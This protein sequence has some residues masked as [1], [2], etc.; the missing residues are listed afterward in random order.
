MTLSFVRQKSRFATIILSRVQRTVDAILHVQQLGQ[1][2][3]EG[4]VFCVSGVVF[5][6]QRCK[7][8]LPLGDVDAVGQLAAGEVELTQLAL[9]LGLESLALGFPFYR[10]EL[11]V[12]G[13][14]RLYSS[15]H[16]SSSRSSFDRFLLA[17]SVVFASSSDE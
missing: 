16:L 8:A 9:V 11:V 3:A 15:A 2:S 4:F 12:G 1:L 6:L 13:L 14:K 5:A 10:V 17:S 7:L